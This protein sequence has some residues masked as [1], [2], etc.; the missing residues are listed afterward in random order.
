[1]ANV[2]III[3]C[4]YGVSVC[5]HVYEG[6]YHYKCECQRPELQAGCVSVHF[7]FVFHAVSSLSP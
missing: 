5:V 7:Y 1:M 3:I 6:T 4:V 2:F